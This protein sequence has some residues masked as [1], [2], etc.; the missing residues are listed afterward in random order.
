[1]VEDDLVEVD[2]RQVTE[3]PLVEDDVGGARPGDQGERA[4]PE[5]PGP[6]RERQLEGATREVAVPEVVVV[7]D[8]RRDADEVR[9]PEMSELPLH[10]AAVLTQPRPDRRCTTMPRRRR[11]RVRL[12]LPVTQG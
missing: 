7:D 8:L 12:I 11:V 5:R 2:Q 9:V 3:D 10:E 6:E 4:A 1:L